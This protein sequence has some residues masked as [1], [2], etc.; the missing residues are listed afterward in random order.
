MG[1][2]QIKN[3]LTGRIIGAAMRVH[4]AL[5]PGLLESVY[6]TCLAYELRSDGLAVEVR[7]DPRPPP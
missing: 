4:S 5:G 2:L 6:E 7:F 3:D 1:E